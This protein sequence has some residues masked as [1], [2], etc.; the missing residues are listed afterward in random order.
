[1][2][3][4]I[5]QK[6]AILSVI[7][8]DLNYF[9]NV[10][11]DVEDLSDTAPSALHITVE[12]EKNSKRLIYEGND[13]L[14]ADEIEKKLKLSEIPAMDEEEMGLYV[15]QIKKLYAEKNYHA[16]T[17]TTATYPNRKWRAIR[18]Y[19]PSAKVK[20][21]LLKRVLFKGNNCVKQQKITQ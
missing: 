20:K 11:V 15:E 5:Q 9:N 13:N 2:M 14:T 16:V 4:L 8:Y 12:E 1:M 17:I 6:R 19:L 7:L 3:C 21:L 18:P 10:T